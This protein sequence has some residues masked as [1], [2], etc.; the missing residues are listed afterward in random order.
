MC[1]EN[2]PDMYDFICE[3]IVYHEDGDIETLFKRKSAYNGKCIMHK[4]KFGNTLPVYVP[5]KYE[6]YSNPVPMIQLDDSV[7]DY[8]LEANIRVLNQIIEEHRIKVIHANHAVLMSVVARRVAN[9]HKLPYAIMPHGSAIEYAV[10]KDKRFFD[11]A[12]NT[13]DDA[14]RIYV[15]GKEIR[16]RIKGLFPE[17]PDVESKM[18]E[19]NLGVDTSLFNPVEVKDRKKIINELFSLLKGVKR[20]KS[21]HDLQILHQVLK[22]DISKKELQEGIKASGVYNSKLTDED[23]EDK[24]KVID[25]ERDKTILF[26]GRLIASKGL[27]SIIAAM[28][29]ILEKEPNA[30]LIV[31][32]HGPQREPLEVLIW[33]L[34]NGH[35]D[36][37]HNIIEWGRELEGNE[38]GSLEETRL[39]FDHLQ[40]NNE[41]DSY[42]NKAKIHIKDG[43]VIFT[44]YLTHRELRCLFPACDVAIFPSVVAEAGPLVF[45]ESM[46]SGCFPIGTYF[47]GMGAS[48][49]SVSDALPKDIV[50]IMK[51]SPQANLTVLDIIRNVGKAL[52]LDSSYNKILREVAVE[53]YDWKNISRRLA[54]DLHALT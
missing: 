44:G 43:S 51:L 8:Y 36:L 54:A 47:A 22:A 21:D 1:Q 41:L 38:R 9:Q 17:L 24:L 25:W 49:D 31:V 29:E 35:V 53:K 30:R 14:H 16:S 28:P 2:H 11:Y 48:I 3:T 13:F 32:G 26:V 19:L 37:V 27:H 23:A 33:A 12:Q 46:A 20:G 18:M 4:P 50:D 6:E 45:L 39:F 34:K 40:K 52:Y 7:L 42:F 10:K 15:I 5:D